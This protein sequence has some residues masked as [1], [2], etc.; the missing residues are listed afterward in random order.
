MV[1]LAVSDVARSVG[2]PIGVDIE[3]IDEI[4]P[5]AVGRMVNDDERAWINAAP[6]L[7]ERNLRMSQTWTSIEAILKAEGVGFSIDP[8]KDG[9]PG[10]WNT[11]SVTYGR[12]LISCAARSKPRIVVKEHAFR[13]A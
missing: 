7:Q 10:G 5:V 3:A 2:G 1:V 8:R 13:V 11:S 12:C 6:N 9:M 4:A